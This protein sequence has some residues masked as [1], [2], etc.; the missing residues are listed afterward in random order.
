[1]RVQGKGRGALRRP[2]GS[3]GRDAR[4]RVGA[5]VAGPGRRPRAPL[6]TVRARRLPLSPIHRDA[7][8]RR[9]GRAGVRPVY[10]WH[11]ASRRETDVEHMVATSEAHD[12]GLCAADAGTR[13]RFASD[14]LKLTLAAPAV[15]RHRK[16]GKDAGEWL[17]RE[18]RCWFAAR[19]VA[20]K[21][22]YRLTVDAREARALEGVLSRCASTAM[23]VAGGREAALSPEAP[24][25]GEAEALRRWDTDGNGRITCREARAHGIAPVRR[26]HP[27][28]RFMRDG[29][30][31]GVVCE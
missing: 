12:S 29:D 5:D 17:P 19:V 30:G 7:H 23:M 9:H 2:A 1:M 10:G 13:R 22:K 25:P 11:F 18:N 3:G 16:S 14:L 31:D 8:R 24:G 20:V 4:G 27:A 21:R 26:G 6:H 15:N 28:W